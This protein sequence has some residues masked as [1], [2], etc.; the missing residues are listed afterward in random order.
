MAYKTKTLYLV[1]YFP[2]GAFMS[3]GVGYKGRLVS[4]AKKTAIVNRLRRIGV[5]A[6][7]EKFKVRA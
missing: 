3:R 4:P 1:R 2:A 6:F 7:A 5:D